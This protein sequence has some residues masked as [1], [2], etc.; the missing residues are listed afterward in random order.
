MEL[1]TARLWL[2]VNVMVGG[3]IEDD[4]WR[5]HAAIVRRQQR[6][7]TLLQV[8]SLQ[9]WDSVIRE[10]RHTVNADAV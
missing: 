1:E 10:A 5:T 6:L 7:L 9:E 4:G 3:I 2:R 8:P